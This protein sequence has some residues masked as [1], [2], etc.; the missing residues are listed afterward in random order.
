MFD[1]RLIPSAVSRC[2]PETPTEDKGY[3]ESQ[4]YELSEYN[5]MPARYSTLSSQL[6]Q[7][8]DFY[9]SSSTLERGNGLYSKEYHSKNPFTGMNSLATPNNILI[10]V[11]FALLIILIVMV[12]LI[13]RVSKTEITLKK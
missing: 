5:F 2:R 13:N 7:L 6:S 12:I 3:C 11:A 4:S 10:I 8:I 1:I 9:F